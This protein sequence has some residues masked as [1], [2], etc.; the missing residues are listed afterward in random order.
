MEQQNDH[1]SSQRD[2][3]HPHYSKDFILDWHAWKQPGPG[4][5]KDLLGEED[6]IEPGEGSCYNFALSEVGEERDLMKEKD[7]QELCRK[8][9]EGLEVIKIDCS[10]RLYEEYG[11]TKEIEIKKDEGDCCFSIALKQLPNLRSFE[12]ARESSVIPDT[13]SFEIVS[14][15]RERLENSFYQELY[16]EK[17]QN[18][19][20]GRPRKLNNIC[21]D[22]LWSVILDNVCKRANKKPIRQRRD[23]KVASICR[24]PK[25]VCV[26]I[27]KHVS[28]RAS[29][30][31]TDIKEVIGAYAEAFTVGFL[32]T[33]FDSEAVEDKIRLFCQFIV[34]AYPESKVERIISLLK[35]A[36][37][38]SYDECKTL[39]HQTKIRK[40]S[41]KAN[42]QDIARQ[43]TCFKNIIIKLLSKLDSTNLKDKQGYKS[44]LSSLLLPNTPTLSHP[45]YNPT[46]L[47]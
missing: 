16:G 26:D 9:V 29:Y 6:Y 2:K 27:L 28:S 40:L 41:S 30:K 35:E 20:R 13:N 12:N 24:N 21:K 14:F 31:S 17:K 36:N 11:E 8:Y 32:P 3:E 34:L 19:G 39:L 46:I 45:P 10:G 5:T 38:L 4:Q 47:L 25:K 37:Y 44:V 22:V 23:G 43:N 18:K 15:L 33:F 1:P 7:T 42:F